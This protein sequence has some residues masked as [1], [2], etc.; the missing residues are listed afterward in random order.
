[1]ASCYDS[2]DESSGSIRCGEFFDKLEDLQATEEGLCVMGS[3]CYKRA[4]LSRILH[5]ISDECLVSY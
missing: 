3:V 1:M 2:G 4:V 5:Q